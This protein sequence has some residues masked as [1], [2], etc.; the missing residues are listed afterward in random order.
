MSRVPSSASTYY[1]RGILV[2][3]SPLIQSTGCARIVSF[4][5]IC[6]KI[7]LPCWYQDSVVI[8]GS[9][10]TPGMHLYQPTEKHCPLNGPKSVTLTV[11]TDEN[12]QL[13]RACYLEYVRGGS[14]PRIQH[15]TILTYLSKVSGEQQPKNE[16]TYVDVPASDV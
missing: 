10:A 5:R 1:L 14:Y 4:D 16:S 6:I 2:A 15:D 3:I 8:R 13:H 11:P 9:V 7:I 12:L